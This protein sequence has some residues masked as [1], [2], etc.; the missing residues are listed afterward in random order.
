M[1]SLE[2][3][4]DL[5][6]AEL[7]RLYGAEQQL[8][9]SLPLLAKAAN[10]PELKSLFE[11]HLE[12]TQG[13]QRRLGELFERLDLKPGRETCAAMRALIEEAEDTIER[14]TDPVVGDAALVV[15]AQKIEHYEIAGY[16]SV[17]TFARILG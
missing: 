12:E 15:A 10:A 14:D 3:L 16:G 17:R 13:H 11:G 6:V 2:S 1:D 4:H 8:T 7:K 9:L 5:F